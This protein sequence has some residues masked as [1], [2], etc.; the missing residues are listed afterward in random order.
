MDIG[1]NGGQN[2]R[3]HSIV[4][5]SDYKKWDIFVKPDSSLST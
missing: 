3:Y 4:I 5:Y 1:K 2:I